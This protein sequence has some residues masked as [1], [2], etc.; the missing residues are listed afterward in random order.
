MEPEVSVIIPVCNVEQYLSECL[1]SA[2]SQTVENIEVICINDGSTDGSLEI[3]KCYREKDP[4][5]IIIDKDNAGYGAAMNDGLDAAK[6]RYVA[7]LESDDLIAKDAYEKLVAAADKEEADIV[8][9]D[10][11]E[12]RGNAAEREL[13]HIEICKDKAQ[14]NTCI[15]P[16]KDQWAFFVPMMNCLG[17]FNRSFIERNGI[18]HQE[19]PGASHQDLGFWFKTFS[20]ANRVLFLNQPF[21][22]YRQDNE[23]SS[24]KSDKKAFFVKG[25]YDEIYNFLSKRPTTKR[26]ILPV[27]FRRKFNSC[28]YVYR[29]AELSLMLPF[30]RALGEDYRLS[31]E[32]GEFNFAGFSEYEKSVLLQIMEDPDS[33]Y[34]NSLDKVVEG[35]NNTINLLK[36]ELARIRSLERRRRSSEMGNCG[37]FDTTSESEGSRSGTEICD[38]NQDDSVALSVIIPVYNTESYLEECL[39][40]VLSQSFDRFEVICI[41]DGSTDSSLNV[42]ESYAKK[43]SR[44]KIVRQ[45]NSGQAVARNHGLRIA[46]GRYVQFI[47]SD[48]YILQGAFEVLVRR[49]DRDALDVLL[50]DGST[51]FE[52]SALSSQFGNMQNRYRRNKQYG[53]ILTGVDMFVALSKDGMYRV[54]PCIAMYRRA[55]LLANDVRFPEGVIYEDNVFVA[56]A[57]L[58]AMRSGH[59]NEAYYVR[60]IRNDS[61]MTSPKTAYHF[62][63]YY[64]VYCDLVVLSFQIGL[65]L[66]AEEYFVKELQAIVDTMRNMYKVLAPGEKENIDSIPPLDRMIVRRL[67]EG[68][69]VDSREIARLQS[70]LDDLYSSNSWRIG[71]VVTSIP[72]IIK[73][74][75]KRA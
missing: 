5:I 37:A 25:E 74:T 13:K 36:S 20:C 63:S 15:T 50:F 33:Y 60:R 38:N 1:D 54:Q 70:K 56:K 55:Y 73:R 4:R 8:K 72:R 59:E 6:G 53:A 62:L 7:F 9:A 17:V 49:M 10:Y 18:R 26:A 68:L 41:D 24:M 69:T 47:D 31:L 48:D 40:S 43:D 19:T 32:R 66:E 21:Y 44:V 65:P 64:R 3:L 34:L 61:T 71:R 14:Y 35:C 57:L 28:L 11:Y 58:C 22:M 75:M 23:Q 27:F 46:S 45:S 12:L 2:L 39:D 51:V 52:S 16:I 30:I 67:L 29:K 42:L